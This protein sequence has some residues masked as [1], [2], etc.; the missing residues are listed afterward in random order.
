MQNT[1]VYF[2][3]HLVASILKSL[4]VKYLFDVAGN[5]L[6]HFQRYE[7]AKEMFEQ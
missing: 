6:L 1:Q 5:L 7:E 2:D 3:E 4:K